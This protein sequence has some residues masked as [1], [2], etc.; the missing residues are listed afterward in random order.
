MAPAATHETHSLRSP[1][2]RAK[3]R[4][5]I[6]HNAI[7]RQDRETVNTMSSSTRS[8]RGD[9][10]GSRPP[11]QS[12]SQNS[13]PSSSPSSVVTYSRK[14]KHIAIEDEKYPQSVYP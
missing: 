6:N 11:L 13:L 9:M 2:Y 8:R 3:S 10:S 5:S 14:R 4:Q 7:T 1:T 12:I